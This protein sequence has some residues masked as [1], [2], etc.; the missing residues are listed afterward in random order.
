MFCPVQGGGG[1]ATATYGRAQEI[2]TGMTSCPAKGCPHRG[3]SQ[4]GIVDL[5]HGPGGGRPVGPTVHDDERV[6]QGGSGPGPLHMPV[7]SGA[8]VHLLVSLC[9]VWLRV[10]TAYGIPARIVGA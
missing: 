3:G 8:P 10:W 4:G 2:E 9:C 5:E 1:A 7:W 6:G